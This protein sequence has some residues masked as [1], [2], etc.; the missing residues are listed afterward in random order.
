MVPRTVA[1]GGIA[2]CGGIVFCG[3]GGGGLVNWGGE[4]GR[5]E[6]RGDGVSFFC[7]GFLLM[8]YFCAFVIKNNGIST[9][10]R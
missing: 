5:G 10:T 3:G 4:G 7:P 1:A 6:G 2:C 8:R 9:R